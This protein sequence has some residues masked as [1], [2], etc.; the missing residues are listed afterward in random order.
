DEEA[1]SKAYPSAT[2]DA[3]DRSSADA[4]LASHL[5]FWTGR[6]CERVRQLMERSG[7][8]RDK[9]RDRPESLETT[10]L[11]QYAQARDVCQ[12]KPISRLTANGLSVVLDADGDRQISTLEPLPHT[13][14]AGKP[15][16]VV[17]NY[18]EVF[19]RAG[20]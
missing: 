15:K 13:T 2:G 5:H 14:V 10:V 8:V 18:A 12:D 16:P 11:A 4:A 9:W 6:N 17:E 3:Y 7:L 20:V 19:R 1:L